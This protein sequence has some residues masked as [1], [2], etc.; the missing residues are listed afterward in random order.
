MGASFVVY[1]RNFAKNFSYNTD[2]QRNERKH[3]M[4]ARIFYKKYG[5]GGK[6]E[7]HTFD[8]EISSYDTLPSGD[9]GHVYIIYAKDGYCE[10]L[11]GVGPEAEP[12]CIK[13]CKGHTEGL[14]FITRLEVDGKVIVGQAE[15]PPG[16]ERSEVRHAG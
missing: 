4:H 2:R 14:T 13:S 8:G 6:Q 11:S 1:T 9:K 15:L 7:F 3:R 5:K 10:L 12:D 16:P